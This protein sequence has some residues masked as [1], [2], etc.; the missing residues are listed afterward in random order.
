MPPGCGASLEKPWCE[1][2][3]PVISDHSDVPMTRLGPQRHMKKIV[4]C[5]AEAHVRTELWEPQAVG[6]QLKVCH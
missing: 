1:A 4:L 2:V 5:W 3:A 6:S